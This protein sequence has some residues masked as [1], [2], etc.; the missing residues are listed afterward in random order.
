MG[1]SIKNKY[2][3]I[4]VNSSNNFRILNYIFIY[5]SIIIVV[6]AY[7]LY[8]GLTYALAIFPQM[9]KVHVSKLEPN[10]QNLKNKKGEKIE[11]LAFNKGL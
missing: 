2:L 8:L 1:F 7:S 11:I 10:F 3:N 6:G 4:A 5:I 9:S